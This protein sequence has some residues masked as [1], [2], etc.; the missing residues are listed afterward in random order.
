MHNVELN[1]FIDLINHTFFSIQN[2]T[3]ANGINLQVPNIYK[4]MFSLL[5]VGNKGFICEHDI[6]QMI[7]ALSNDK[8]GN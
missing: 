8:S 4:L 3:L 6:F 2:Y 7:W 5:D 1:S